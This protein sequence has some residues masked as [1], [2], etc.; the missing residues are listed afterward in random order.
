MLAIG[1]VAIIAAVITVITVVIVVGGGKPGPKP[2][3]GPP[4]SPVA[5]AGGPT[6]FR[7]EDHGSTVD[8]FWNDNSGGAAS[9]FIVYRSVDGPLQTVSV[10]QGRTMEEVTQLDPTKG[11]CFRLGAVIPQGSGTTTAFADTSVRGCI[12][13]SPGTTPSSTAT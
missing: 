10:P 6:G 1:A 9:Y 4:P 5:S 7:A 11:Y 2:T 13:A 3:P 12:A 8:L